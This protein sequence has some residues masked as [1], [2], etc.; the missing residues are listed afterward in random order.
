MN[1]HR[2]A[3]ASFPTLK[4]FVDFRA[5]YSNNYH[6]NKIK[7]INSVFNNY[8]NPFQYDN[9][10]N[11]NKKKEW[12]VSDCKDFLMDT[13]SEYSD[14]SDGTVDGDVVVVDDDEDQNDSCK[15]VELLMKIRLKLSAVNAFLRLR[16]RGHLLTSLNVSNCNIT[17]NIVVAV[18]H[19]V[20]DN[21]NIN[22]LDFSNNP[23]FLNKSEKCKH[24]HNLLKNGK[25]FSLKL[26]NCGI[27][28]KGLM[29]I[30]KGI[31]QSKYLNSCE[32]S[33]NNIGPTGANWVASFSKDFSVNSLGLL[34]NGYHK[35][36]PFRRKRYNN[37]DD[38]SSD[39]ENSS[40]DEYSKSD[41]EHFK[42]EHSYDY[43]NNETNSVIPNRVDL[44]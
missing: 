2:K 33:H 8:F 34:T 38:D 10:N 19:A 13:K 17:G 21:W 31:M 22:R 3:F 35:K 9:S 23:N 5:S 11:N 18:S 25:L 29:Q 27:T 41:E 12:Q 43:Y 30:A 15:L 4:S 28:D 39:S 40:D 36:A 26:N 20:S 6:N 14:D 16:K 1:K 7:S 32:L 24:I 37:N 42:S 44:L